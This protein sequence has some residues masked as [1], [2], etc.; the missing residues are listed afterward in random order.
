MSRTE[1]IYCDVCKK[2]IEDFN[3][4]DIQCVK[5]FIRSIESDSSYIG[6]DVDFCSVQCLINCVSK[7][8]KRDNIKLQETG[9]E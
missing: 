6:C 4:A 5:S 2:E 1:T 8:I 3:D 9:D 7:R